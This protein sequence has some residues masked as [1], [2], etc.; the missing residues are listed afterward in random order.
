[1]PQPGT[2]P[3]LH[4]V[5]AREGGLPSIEA[6]VGRE[7]EAVARLYDLQVERVERLLVAVMGP[8]RELDDIVQ[9]VFVE[10]LDALPRFRGTEPGMLVAFLDRI[11]V[12]V[13]RTW[14]RRRKRNAWLFLAAPAELPEIPA[15][16][17]EPRARA[18]LQVALGI[19]DR[20]PVD[21][22][23][24]FSL[25]RI[26]GFR[27]EEIAQLVEASLATVKRRIDR[28]EQRLVAEARTQPLL[29]SWLED[30][31]GPT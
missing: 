19:L 30:H 8:D 10:V 5:G 9:R 4:L 28:A 26:E 15:S 2:T 12:N 23:V 24:A 13:A 18:A 27:L 17:G 22:R 21:E 6:L 16:F 14:I 29:W 20:L 1:M 7:P 11:T 31:D 25:R 3:R